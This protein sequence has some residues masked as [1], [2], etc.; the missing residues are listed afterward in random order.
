AVMA[1]LAPALLVS[2]IATRDSG[3]ICFFA[4]GLWA[5]SCGWQEN[6]KRDWAIAALCFFAAFLCKY[7]VAIFFPLLVLLACVHALKPKGKNPLFLFA[8]PLFA[9]CATYGA[10]HFRELAQLLRYG[11]AYN[12]LRAPT[13]EA[14]KIYI[15]NRWDF[16]LIALATLPVFAFRQW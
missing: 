9:A 8:L 10:V 7:L 11:S 16:W 6:R 4:L 13:G 1:V 5:F 3:S 15:W 12:A 14:W 2:R